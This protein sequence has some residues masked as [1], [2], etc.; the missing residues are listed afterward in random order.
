MSGKRE[1][2]AAR[3]TEVDG[4]GR[5]FT[6]RAVTYDVV[7]DYGSVFVRGV[8]NESLSKR[9]PVIAWAHDWSEPIGRATD[10][11][12]RDDGL[13]LTGKLSD[14]DAVPRARQ[15]MAQ[16]ADGT[17]T[18]VSVGFSGTVRRSPTDDE[19]ERWPGAREVI[20]RAD[21]DETSM[22]LRG[23]VPGAKVLSV[24]SGEQVDIDAVVEIAKRKAAGELTDAE[25]QAALDLLAG[26]AQAPATEGEEPPTPMQMI[27]AT[28]PSDEDV[29]ALTADIDAALE[30]IGRSA[31]R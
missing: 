11:E 20:T 12:E 24:R 29:A 26:T 7:D 5:T 8:F 9:L 10:W 27:E 6:A 28:G 21:L 31:R 17:I 19:M 13:Y 15:T 22:V 16:L 25:A 23:A 3:V 2:R 30:A 4:E 18:D 1:H 14:P